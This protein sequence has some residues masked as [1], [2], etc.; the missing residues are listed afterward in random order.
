MSRLPIAL[1]A[2]AA[3]C[4]F[5]GAPLA[6]AQQAQAEVPQLSALAP[7]NLAKKRPKAAFDLTGTWF[8]DTK[9]ASFKFGP[10]YPKFL[11]EAQKEYDAGVKAT[12]EHRAYKDYIGQCYPAG[13]PMIMTRVWPIAM[14]QLP[15]VIYM[16]SGFENAF[17]AI[18]LDGRP[19]TDP[20]L[21]V[22]SFNGE[23]IGHWEGDTLVVDTNAFTPEHH[24]IDVGIPISDQFHMVERLRLLDKGQSLE[25]AYTM[26]D[27][28][29]WEGEWKSLHY[30]RR[31]DDQDIT[32]VECLPD[33]DQHLPATQSK[34]NVR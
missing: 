18:Y 7:E 16:V 19:H 32:E 22:R 6:Q 25:I 13:M 34:L 11:P 28:K 29:M 3:A 9:K 17:R 8:V 30:W 24:T 1:G 14:V 5:M 26:T 31:V 21:V 20:D 10:P 12:A 27:P 15:T 4:A 33:L 23:S 2:A